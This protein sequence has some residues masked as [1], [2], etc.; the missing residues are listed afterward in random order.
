MPEL[1][2][3][4]LSTTLFFGILYHVVKAAVRNGIGEAHAL[5]E[6]PNAGTEP[7]TDGAI[8]QTTCLHCGE[9]YDMDYPRCPHCKQ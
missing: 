2:F 3:I 1:P 7:F 5:R 6:N 8:S 9:D 4:V